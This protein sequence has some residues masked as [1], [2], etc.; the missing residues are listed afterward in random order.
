VGEVRFEG[1]AVLPVSQLARSFKLRADRPYQETAAREGARAV[2]ERVRQEGYFE[3]RVT[4]GPPDWHA[5]TNRVDLEVRVASGPRF[6][7]AF[8]GRSALAEPLLDS[9][10]TFRSSGS[11]DR[12]E[13]EASA[14]QI[15]AA[16]RERGYHFATAEPHDTRDGDVRVI[17][18]AI[19]EGPQVTVESVTFAGRLAIRDSELARQIETSPPGLFDRGLFRQEVLDRDVGVLLAYLRSRGHAEATVGPAEVHFSDDRSRVRIAIPVAEGPRLRVGAVSIAGARVATA[20]ELEAALPFERGDPWEARRADDGQRSIEAFYAARGYHGAAV[21]FDTRRH[22]STVDLHY[23]VDEGERTRIGRVL[24]RGLLL[25]REEVVRRTLPFQPGDVLLP[26][27]LLDG[28]RRLGDLPAFDAVS[29]DPLRPPP[30]PFA[31]VEVTVRERKPWH[32]DFGFGYSNADGV[33]GFVELG[34]DDVLGLGASLSV[35]QRLSGGGDSTRWAERTDVLGHVPY[36]LGTPWWLDLDIFQAMSGQLG[37]DL[38]HAGIWIGARRD[39]FPD[40]IRGLRGDLRYRLE[41]VEYS[42]VDPALAA[43][44]VTPGRQLISSVTP[45]LTLDRR[46]EPLDPTRGSLHRI[47]VET[48]TRHLGSDVEFVKGQLE[49]FWFLA[50]PPPTVVALGGR[51]GLAAPYG[52]S[53]ALAIQ[54]RFFAGGATTVRGFR[55]DRLGPLDARG[56]PTGGNARVVLNLEWR[57]PIWRWLGGT[58]FVDSGAVTPEIADLRPDQF[59]TGTGGGLRLRTPVGPVRLDV[60]YALQPISGESRTQFY[61]TV[62][63]PF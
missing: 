22:D 62:G 2:E 36:V 5:A 21:R 3:A 11:A 46:D 20:R 52:G 34:H 51:L 61:V 4:V 17:R 23:D 55:Q 8:E 37:Y 47:S 29:V 48:G 19:D 33:R 43:S 35:R 57:F 32:L 9:A 27:K 18:F 24:L 14:R 26:G 30:V 28:Q 41:S 40:E 38:S 13:Q 6:R 7:V 44:D 45:V 53:P 59:R 49:T 10:L 25:A 54:D 31:D 56:N 12:F 1:D 16:Y 42:N 58:V 63:D 60:G 15:E 39:L 50:W